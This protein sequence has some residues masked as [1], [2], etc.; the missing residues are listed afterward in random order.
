MSKTTDLI[1]TALFTALTAAGAMLSLPLPFTPVPLTLATLASM[2]AGAFLGSKYGSLS[3]LIYILLGAIGVPVFHNFTAGL[4]ILAGPTGG[5]LLGYIATAFFTGILLKKKSTSCKNSLCLPFRY[6][7]LLYF[8]NLLVHAFNRHISP[9]F[10]G[11]LRSSISPGR[12]DQNSGSSNS[13]SPIK[14]CSYTKSYVKIK[15]QYTN[16]GENHVKI[17]SKLL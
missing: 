6:A 13:D 10:P 3:Q 1:L 14:A 11:K 2:L 17:L 12:L 8:R 7:I 15:P 5:Y 4:G 9:G 16:R